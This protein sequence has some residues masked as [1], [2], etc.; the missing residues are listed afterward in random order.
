MSEPS[1]LQRAILLLGDALKPLEDAFSQSRAVSSLAELGIVVNAG[2]ANSV[3]SA[4]QAMAAGTAALLQDVS[5]LTAAIDADDT[6]QIAAKSLSAI[7]RIVTVI[8]SI[9]SLQS[10]ISG[11]GLPPAVANSFAER[12]F[13]FLLVRIF[14]LGTGI[15]EILELLAVLDR[16]S[17]NEGSTDPNLPPHV[18]STFN[19]GA[20]GDWITNPVGALGSHYGWSTA[21]FTGEALLRRLGAILG[22]FGAPVFLDESGPT[23]ALDFVV[24][25]IL[26]RTDLTPRG[27]GIEMRQSLSPG[28]I[29][30]GVDDLVITLDTA[31]DV[32]FGLGLTIQPPFDFDFTLPP[33]ASSISG[34]VTLTIAADRTSAAEKFLIFGEPD[35]SR[36]EFGRFA[37]A[38]SLRFDNSGVT[39]AIRADVN[40]GKI[41]IALDEADGFIAKILS[42]VKMESD[43]D[44]GVGLSADTGIF[45]EGSAT[46][47]IQLPIHIDLGPVEISAVTITLGIDG[48]KFPLGVASDIKAV[49]GPLVAVVQQMGVR[50]DFELSDNRDG[51]A[52][53][54]NISVNFQPPTGVG[55][56]I[57]AGAVKGGGFLGIDVP[58]GE[59]T[60][61][62]QLSILEMVTV[63]AIGIIN[64]KMPD[65]SE[66]FSFLAIISVEFNPG[67][68]LGFGF[69]LLG[70]GGLVGL[71][72]AMDLD[73]LVAG[74]RSGSI[75]TILFPKDIIAN[76]SKIISDLKAFF[77]PEQDTFLIGPMTKFGWGTPTLISLSLGIIIEIPGNIAIVGK[78][79]VAIPDERLPL[80]IIQV[81]FMGAIEFDKK[82]G[83]FFAALY[84]SRVIYITLEGGI[85][86]LAAFGDDSNF[87]VTVGGFHPSYNP[88]A[89][90]FQDVPRIAINILNTPVAK[91]IVTAYF[92][93]TSNTVQFG[94]K[95]TLYFGI[96]IASIDGH[97]A[98]DALFQFSPFYFIITISASLS[99]K[100][101]GAGLF[102]VRFKG[103]LEGTSPWHVEGTGSISILFW[104]VDVD[105]SHTWG[106]KEDTKLPPIS[107]MPLLVEEF[108]KVENWT[109]KLENV[110]SLLVSLR[111]IDADVDLVL[112]PLGSLSI[113]QR[114]IP[115]GITLDK[116]GNQRPDDVNKFS[117]NAA[118]VGIEKRGELRES[119]AIGQFQNLK[120]SEK[121]SA[122]DYEKEEAGLELSVTG[123]QTKTSFVSKRI[124]RYEQIII[125]SNFK[126]MV[127]VFVTLISG[128]FTHFLGGNAVSRM[129]ISAR[130]QDRKHLFDE[131]IKVHPN[132]YVV[133]NAADNSPL[134]SAPV[135]FMSQASAKEYM[136]NQAATDPGFA[137]R[138]H[139][140]RPHELKKAA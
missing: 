7:E 57:D 122:S 139:I 8:N 101:F 50:V 103:S 77:P 136:A 105:F 133:A 53:P 47:E 5:D 116:I 3:A 121:L 70:V 81:A 85:G 87:I 18:I 10:T 37:L 118:T 114:A 39:P 45:F 61:M 23:P 44:L 98:F 99:V 76:A 138:A 140:I 63:T 132:A 120:D 100:L 125:D 89:L 25:K 28:A 111:T 119:F 26:P 36:M 30:F 79:T 19:F 59:Y 64:T 72:R 33:E 13:N 117:L 94:A 16:E 21:G 67:I 115:L 20:L 55:L 88:P 22:R 35:K 65:G 110:N 56:S 80:I 128:L 129:S 48:N 14:E 106:D 51:N 6:S 135:S 108:N 41:F 32:P 71:N 93:V 38:S 78:L 46:L 54:V 74:A 2:Q 42:G 9:D 134:E 86:V 34:E 92:A 58:R 124:A 73:A 66:G 112:H 109:A 113:T 91:V 60:G 130:S 84:D 43:F 24:A 97:L 127:L 11:L 49:L 1:T 4:A 90:P 31:I 40:E 123:N 131:K 52:G 12:L 83:W 17:I 96:S 82:R 95:A 62:L 69:T 102:S 126:R 107:V 75:D 137:E 15:N 29:E 27:L 68:Q 104:D